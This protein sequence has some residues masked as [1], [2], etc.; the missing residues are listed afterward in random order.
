MKSPVSLE[1]REPYRHQHPVEEL[2]DGCMVFL[3]GSRYCETDLLSNV[4]WQLFGKSSPGRDPLQAIC[5]FAHRHIVVRSEFP[6]RRKQP[7]MSTTSEGY[8]ASLR[9]WQSHSVGP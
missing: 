3:P 8:I 4:A 9:T 1:A 6:D 5:G 2:P 7:G